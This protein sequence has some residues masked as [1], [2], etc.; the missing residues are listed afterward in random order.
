MVWHDGTVE[1]SLTPPHDISE[2]QI[3]AYLPKGEGAAEL[4]DLMRR[5]Q[6][7]LKDH[8][9]NQ[10]R[11]SRGLRPA[12]SIWLWGQG[13]KPALNSFYE[14]YRLQGAVISAVDLAKG[15]GICAGLQ[16]IEVAGATGNIHTN[17][18]GKAEAALAAFKSGL[19]LVYLHIEAPDEAGHRG[20]LENKVKAIAKIDSEVLG[21]LLAE[22]PKVT[23][24]FKILL[25]PD[26]PTPLCLR[27]H[28]A[29]P[30]P[31]LI[32]QHDKPATKY[33]KS[34]FDEESASQTGL[35]IEEGYQL[36]D[37]FIKGIF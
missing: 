5:S 31:F 4:L 37:R 33:S 19:D 3:G 16:V 11:V 20:E 29:D 28:V 14:K 12:N 7:I 32:Y 30:V 18:Q 36:M 22:L 1:S 2:R 34:V 15:L 9:V 25:L 23:P 13:K 8:P 24:E 21:W 26:H 6:I 17:F 35:V 10:A 27:T